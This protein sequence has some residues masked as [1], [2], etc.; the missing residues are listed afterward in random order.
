MTTNFRI[1]AM[2]RRQAADAERES[3][4]QADAKATIEIRE[5]WFENVTGPEDAVSFGPGGFNRVSKHNLLIDQSGVY[6]RL[7]AV[8]SL[9]RCGDSARIVSFKLAGIVDSVISCSFKSKIHVDR[10]LTLA[11]Q[12][13]INVQS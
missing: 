8:V 4:Q 13:G 12:A 10:F 7:N 3:K 2:K 5:K 6:I 11:A 1:G 9:S